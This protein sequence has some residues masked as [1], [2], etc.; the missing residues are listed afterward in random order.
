MTLKI[1]VFV[2]SSDLSLLKEPERVE[3]RGEVKKLF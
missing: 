3:D 1:N 2:G